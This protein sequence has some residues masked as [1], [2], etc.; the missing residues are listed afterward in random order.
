MNAL[1]VK[2]K[3]FIHALSLVTYKSV[4]VQLAVQQWTQNFE[5]I[6]KNT[7][8]KVSECRKC[9]YKSSFAEVSV[10]KKTNQVSI[11]NYFQR[12]PR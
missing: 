12:W 7:P 11:G 2:L 9:Q 3:H 8:K 5:I 4:I 6:Q 10:K 1:Y